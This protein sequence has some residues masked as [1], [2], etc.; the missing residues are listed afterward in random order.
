MDQSNSNRAATAHPVPLKPAIGHS[1]RRRPP[2]I[3][4]VE[5][6]RLVKGFFRRVL[7]QFD[8]DLSRSVR[9]DIEYSITLER[10]L[11]RAAIEILRRG[12]LHR[13]LDLLVVGPLGQLLRVPASYAGYAAATVTLTTGK[14]D[15]E[16]V[17]A[18]DPVRGPLNPCEGEVCAM[19]EGQVA[20]WLADPARLWRALAMVSGI[21]KGFLTAPLV[22]AIPRSPDPTESPGVSLR[23]R[24]PFGVWQLIE[25]EVFDWID[26]EGEPT[27][28]EQVKLEERIQFLL[29]KHKTDASERTIR[30]HAKQYITAYRAKRLTDK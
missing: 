12:I 29:I 21:D 18:S 28:G 8:G 4:C 22:V 30:D 9:L 16:S 13:E 1:N 7:K 3:S 15:L 26:E 10:K 24:P 17:D 20:L 6:R 19:R 25:E 23:G 27:P 5:A 2:E 14:L 11:D